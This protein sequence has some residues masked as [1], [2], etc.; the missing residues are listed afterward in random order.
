MNKLDY[1]FF[2]GIIGIAAGMVGIGYAIGTHSEVAR[3]GKKLDKS[4]D[5]LASDIP[6]EIDEVVVKRA[7][8]RTVKEEVTRTVNNI[9]KDE[10]HKQVNDIVANEYS[11]I[12]DTVLCKLTESAAK[13]NVDRVKSD[14]EKAAKE[15]ALK[16]FDDN[17]DDILGDFKNNLENVSKIYRSFADMASPNSS[18]ETVLKIV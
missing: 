5:E 17:L 11:T 10:V 16:K 2:M 15:R 6:V 12:K 9:V 4:I 13:I 18:R 3:I 8:E 1:E 14:V 7:I